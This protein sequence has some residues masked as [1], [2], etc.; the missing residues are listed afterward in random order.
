MTSIK[1]HTPREV[2]KYILLDLKQNMVQSYEAQYEL[3]HSEC[4]AAHT[5]IINTWLCSFTKYQNICKTWR[6]MYEKIKRRHYWLGV[7][8]AVF[9][10]GALGEKSIA[11]R[12]QKFS[13]YSPISST[14]ETDKGMV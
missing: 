13:E 12:N 11:K 8:T 9:V 6:P 1:Q 2:S 4:S 7:S 10:L 14:L 5:D 3:V